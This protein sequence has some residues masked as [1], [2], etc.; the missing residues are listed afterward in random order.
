MAT[1]TRAGVAVPAPGRRR[2][3]TAPAVIGVAYTIS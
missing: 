2:A 1:R 3:G